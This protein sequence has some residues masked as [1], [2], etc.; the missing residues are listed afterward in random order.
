MR[1]IANL[2]SKQNGY[3]LC[4]IIFMIV[5]LNKNFTGDDL[6]FAN[7]NFNS[8]NE[9]ASFVYSRADTW[10]PRVIS[11]TLVCI[12]SHISIWCWRVFASILFVLLVCNFIEIYD[13]KGTDGYMAIGLAL[14]IPLDIFCTAGWVTTII[15]YFLPIVMSSY[16]IKL[17][18]KFYCGERF[19]HK[20]FV[21]GTFACI[22]AADSEQINVFCMLMLISYIAY[23]LY[24]TNRLY[25]F[26]LWQFFIFATI[27]AIKTM[28]FRAN[29]LR[30]I[31]ETKK[32]FPEY[33][34]LSLFDKLYLGFD[35]TFNY[36]YTHAIWLIICFLLL[37]LLVCLIRKI[38]KKLYLCILVPCLLCI[39]NET[40]I[41][42]MVENISIGSILYASSYINAIHVM[43]I[44]ACFSL[45]AFLWLIWGIYVAIQELHLAREY[46]Y[47]IYAVLLFG[48]LTRI[49]MGLSSTLYA[50]STRTFATFYFSVVLS[51]GF[52]WR[53]LKEEIENL[54]HYDAL[55]YLFIICTIYIYINN[56]MMR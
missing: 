48:L 2:M 20:N 26:G 23:N 4:F 3:I 52:V 36:L 12:F 1:N 38:E 22:F 53:I 39:L 5:F 42:K 44:S 19:S 56:A 13:L 33:G 41:V 49:L 37:I 51:F 50:S 45:I 47:A 55:K 54:L 25:K 17:G 18:K 32:W 28:Y 24:K 29:A 14:L 15:Y 27:M 40:T 11:I 46:R 43:N 10:E 6:Y 9:F 21:L 31:A 30:N 8:F 35:S 7:I 34:T 16:L